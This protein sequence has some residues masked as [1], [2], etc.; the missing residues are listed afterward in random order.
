MSQESLLKREQLIATLLEG[1]P[2]SYPK[3]LGK[4]FKVGEATTDR[5]K[6]SSKH[7]TSNTMEVRAK[8]TQKNFFRALEE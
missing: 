2:K 1:G 4:D 7:I 8:N 3:L 5:D 6:N